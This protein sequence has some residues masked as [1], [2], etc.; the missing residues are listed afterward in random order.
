METIFALSEEKGKIMLQSALIL[1][2][3]KMKGLLSQLKNLTH[4]TRRM[5]CLESFVIQSGTKIAQELD[6]CTKGLSEFKNQR[7]FW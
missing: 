3:Q 4:V 5:F 7:N 1:S 2:Q 6:K